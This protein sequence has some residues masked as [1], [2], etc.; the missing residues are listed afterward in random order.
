VRKTLLITD[1]DN[2][3]FDWVEVWY[4][5]FSAMLDQI[6]A[7]SGVSREILIPE[8]RAVHQRHGTSEYAF[9]IEEVP[10]LLEFCGGRNPSEVFDQAID[11]FRRARKESLRLY[12]GVQ[13][14]LAEIKH[15]GVMIVAYTESMAFY[16]GY[17][18]RKLELDGLID[19]L[20]SPT[21]HDLPAGMDRDSM[22]KYPAENYEFNHTVHKHTPRGAFKPSAEVL[23]AIVNSTGIPLGNAVYVGD[24]L[25][26]DVVMAQQVGVDNAWAKYGLAQ[27]RA[28]YQLLRDVTHWTDDDVQREREI[29]SI[30]VKPTIVLCQSFSEIISHFTF[31]G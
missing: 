8:I 18:I 26:K 5:S 21:D 16:T 9:L 25:T 28:E 3:L 31:G 4:R 2:T 17:R 23:R 29:Q 14:T 19:V 22:R 7:I 12:P 1:L 27:Q 30:D 24:S 6:E 15:N 13:D 10:S 20:F 11:A